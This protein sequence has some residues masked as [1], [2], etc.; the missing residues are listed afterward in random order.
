MGQSA[1]LTIILQ[2]FS[3]VQLFKIH[4]LKNIEHSPQLKKK[5]L[6]CLLI[7]R[8]RNSVTRSFLNIIE[9]SII[10]YSKIFCRAVIC[11]MKAISE[12]KQVNRLPTHN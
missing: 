7:E 10:L 4:M 12:S 5:E 8:M 9:M 3:P 11:V 2:A 1:L 6:N